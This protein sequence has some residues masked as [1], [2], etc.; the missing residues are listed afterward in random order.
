MTDLK[1]FAVTY[2]IG[3]T[4]R[5]VVGVI[6]PDAEAAK[7]L[8]SD[9]F[10]EGSIWDDT[11]KMPLLFDDFEES[12]V[13]TLLYS[14]QEVS[15][16]PEPDASVKAIKQ[17]ESAFKACQASL[18]GE[19]DTAR[20]FAGKALPHVV[21]EL[22]SRQDDAQAALSTAFIVESENGCDPFEVL[23]V[24]REDALRDALQALGWSVLP[25]QNDVIE[26]PAAEQ[27]IC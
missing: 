27:F 20:D 10:D 19:L 16:F 9:A 22:S 4:H 11:E 6:A 8:A 13:E 2:E 7:Q 26:L 3:Y 15:G 5:V 24:G 21:A 14:T 17:K 23:A 12:A 1:K 18:V 25:K